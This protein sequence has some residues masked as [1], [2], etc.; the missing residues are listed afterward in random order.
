MAFLLNMQDQAQQEAWCFTSLVHLCLLQ[1]Q[2]LQGGVD[3]NALQALQVETL[4]LE[5]FGSLGDIWGI[6]GGYPSGPN[7][8]VALEAFQKAQGAGAKMEGYKARAASSR[9]VGHPVLRERC[10]GQ[11]DGMLGLL[12]EMMM[13][14]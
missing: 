9:P 13:I 1:P 3:N 14:R 7:G 5:N 4:E 6:S 2:S 12:G 10:H 8:C 11:N